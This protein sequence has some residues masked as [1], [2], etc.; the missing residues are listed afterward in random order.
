MQYRFA[1]FNINIDRGQ[2]NICGW[3][4]SLRLR[5]GNVEDFKTSCSFE[6]VPF[7]FALG[8][9]WILEERYCSGKV[10]FGFARGTWGFYINK[11]LF[12]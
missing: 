4:C 1:H 5:S 11:I 7:G 12:F 6:K 9:G 3:K 8:T 10:F 2:N